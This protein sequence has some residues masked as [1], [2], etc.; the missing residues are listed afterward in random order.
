MHNA[1]KKRAPALLLGLSVLVGACSAWGGYE[2]GVSAYQRKNYATALEEFRPSAAEGNAGA[3]FLLGYMYDRGLGVTQ[4]I[5]EAVKWFRKAAEQ[6]EPHAQNELGTMYSAGRGVTQD[7]KE[8]V[9]WFRKA[10]E[11]GN[12][13]AQFNLGLRY[14]EGQ[15]VTQ[16]YESAFA[17]SNIAVAQ[18][19]KDSRKIRDMAE[20]KM[21][22]AQT[23]KA[24]EL[25]IQYYK[26]YVAPFK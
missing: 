9:K 3:Q 14:L 15:G 19:D 20:N 18:G 5:G 24:Y 11:Q 13:I 17:W 4:D 26:K 22:P 1:N 23:E 6:G 21:T 8:A 2:E 12:A 7:D 16:D 25:S 10:A